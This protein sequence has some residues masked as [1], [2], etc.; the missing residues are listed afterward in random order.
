[1]PEYFRLLGL[2]LVDGRLFDQHDGR[3]PDLVVVIVD[4]AWARRFFP[5]ERAVG[6]RLRGGGCTSCPWTT[7]VGVVSDVKYAGLDRPD[8][9]SVYSPM[10]GRESQRPARFRYVLVRTSSDAAPVL[11]VLQRVV[12]ELDPS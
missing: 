5:N 10:P 9:G 1:T 3:T 7:V 4:R 8:E 2:T 11:P 6:K 12:R